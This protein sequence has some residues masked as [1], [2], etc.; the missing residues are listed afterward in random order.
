M[1][2]EYDLAIFNDVIMFF[3]GFL[4]PKYIFLRLFERDFI[5]ASFFG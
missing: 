4:E 5:P 2:N 3:E 1:D